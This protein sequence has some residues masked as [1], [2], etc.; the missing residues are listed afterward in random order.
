MFTLQICKRHKKG[1]YTNSLLLNEELSN[2][3]LKWNMSSELWRAWHPDIEQMK[4]LL[5]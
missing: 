3:T 4:Y 2:K 5:Q 1:E